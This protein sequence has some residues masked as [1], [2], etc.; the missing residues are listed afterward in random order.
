M[1]YLLIDLLTGYIS[2]LPIALDI[3]IGLDIDAKG[4]DG[5]SVLVQMLL[6]FRCMNSFSGCGTSAAVAVAVAVASC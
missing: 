6:L 4:E 3:S 5:F 1:I 2:V